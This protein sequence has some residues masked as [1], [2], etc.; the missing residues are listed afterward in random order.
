M[1]ISFVRYLKLGFFQLGSPFGYVVLVKELV[2]NYILINVWQQLY[3][4]AADLY[5]ILSFFPDHCCV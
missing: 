2:A 4:F 5:V 3:F 1:I